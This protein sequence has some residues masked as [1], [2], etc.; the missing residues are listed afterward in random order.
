MAYTI[1]VSYFNSF[2]LKKVLKNTPG[3]D[4]EWPGLP[5][6]GVNKN[7]SYQAFPFGTG[8]RVGGGCCCFS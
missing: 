6:Y 4:P 1:G 3:N 8:P 7:V 5:W 2:W